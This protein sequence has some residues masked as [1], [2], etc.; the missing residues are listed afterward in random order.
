M[1]YIHF[2][3]FIKKEDFVAQFLGALIQIEHLAV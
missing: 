1:D 3:G 2:Y